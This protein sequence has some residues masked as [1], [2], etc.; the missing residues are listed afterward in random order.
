[1]GLGVSFDN[2]IYAL[3]L[4]WNMHLQLLKIPNSL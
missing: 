2:I 4:I 1:M 3:S